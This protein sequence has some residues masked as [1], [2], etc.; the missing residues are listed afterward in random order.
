MKHDEYLEEEQ[1]TGN[2]TVDEGNLDNND[3]QQNA[4]NIENGDGL[5]TDD[6]EETMDSNNIEVTFALFWISS[7]SVEIFSL[8]ILL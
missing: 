8:R 6:N 5:K 7:F 3:N 2:D 4:E 1:H